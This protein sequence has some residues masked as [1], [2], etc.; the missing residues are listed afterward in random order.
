MNSIDNA[1][2]PHWWCRTGGGKSSQEVNNS[3]VVHFSADLKDALVE[4]RNGQMLT[5]NRNGEVYLLD[6]RGRERKIPD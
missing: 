6:D 4:D 3:G 1:Y 5:T 2:H